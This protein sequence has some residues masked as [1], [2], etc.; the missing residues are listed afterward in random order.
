MNQTKQKRRYF[1]L[2]P[3]SKD[4]EAIVKE[5]ERSRMKSVVAGEIPRSMSSFLSELILEAIQS[6]KAAKPKIQG[7]NP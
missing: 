3:K 6:R 5:Y 7:A 2:S 1:T 4:V